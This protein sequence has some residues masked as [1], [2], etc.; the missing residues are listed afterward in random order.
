VKTG[1]DVTTRFQYTPLQLI[2]LLHGR[3]LKA[4]EVYPVHIHGVTP[5]FKETNMELHSSIANLLQ[6]YARHNTKLLSHASTF[7]LHVKKEQ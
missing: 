7:M 3:G 6:A 5:S 2:N 1:I 4:L